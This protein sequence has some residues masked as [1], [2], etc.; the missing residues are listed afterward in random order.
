MVGIDKPAAGDHDQ[1][2]GTLHFDFFWAA[3]QRTLPGANER[4]AALLGMQQ[5]D[6]LW[7][8]DNPWWLTFD[9]VYMLAR[10]IP[11]LDEQAAAE[12]RGSIGRATAAAAAR[13]LDPALRSTDFVEPWMGAHTVTGAVSLF[14]VAQQVLGRDRVVTDQAL[15]LVLDRRPYI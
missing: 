6:G 4:A 3:L 1:I 8:D 15:Q 7:D 12:V 5:A 9:A 14:A 2:G 11:E 13:S 10:T